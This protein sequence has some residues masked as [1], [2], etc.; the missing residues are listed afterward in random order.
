MDEIQQ[1]QQLVMQGEIDSIKGKVDQILEALLIMARR[2]EE[3][4]NCVTDWNDVLVQRPIPYPRHTVLV[5]NHV[6]YGL[7][8]GFTPPFEGVTTHLIHT[9]R[10]T[11][12]VHT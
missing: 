3:I 1:Q 11:D 7:P 8:P 4:C 2:E 12:G 9:F 10:V 5:P 6:I